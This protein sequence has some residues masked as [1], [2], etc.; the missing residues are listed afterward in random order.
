MSDGGR[1]SGLVV[2]GLGWGI[3]LGVAAGALLIAPAMHNDGQ[4][5]G[6]D[7]SATS[8]EAQRA[9]AYADN[10]DTL[11]GEQSAAIVKD[12]LKDKHVT[13]IRTEG[14]SD[15]DV[16]AVRWLLG[17]AGAK[18]SGE[19]ELASKF[20]DQ[21]SADA[22]SSLIANTLP[23]GAQ[24]SVEDRRPGVHAGE[25][26]SAALLVDAETGE[27]LA[28]AGDRQFVLDAL[29]QAGFV[30]YSGDLVPAD[31]IVIVTGA[32]GDDTDEEGGV[33]AGKGAPD[34]FGQQL[35]AD[36]ADALGKTEPTVLGVREIDAW[37]APELQ[38]ATFVQAVETEA[39][40]IRATLGA[41]GSATS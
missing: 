12:A 8:K 40:R 23:A 33:G 13:V 9:E 29:K 19:L 38:H 16:K 25:S 24:L 20:T 26:L 36:F 34:E 41:A 5:L 1:T 15:E 10:S 4:P 28:P 37:R 39:G 6:Q 11:L 22:L 14:A 35:L 27:P 31:A 17:K 18:D 21:D 32:A 3:A 7:N 30:H 2:T